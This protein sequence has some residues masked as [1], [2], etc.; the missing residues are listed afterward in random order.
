[1]RFLIALR[2]PAA[3][4]PVE[5]DR[6]DFI[7]VGQRAVLFREVSYGADGGEIALH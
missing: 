3:V 7:E 5:P 1:M 6:V 4:Q 2:Y